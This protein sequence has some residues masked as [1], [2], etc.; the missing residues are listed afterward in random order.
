M[1]CPEKW[2][3]LLQ[4]LLQSLHLQVDS[5]MRHKAGR[6]AAIMQCVHEGDLFCLLHE[7]QQCHQL[8]AAEWRRQHQEARCCLCLPP[9]LSSTRWFLAY[10]TV[11]STATHGRSMQIT[12][13]VSYALE[14]LPG[15]PNKAHCRDHNALHTFWSSRARKCRQLLDRHCHMADQ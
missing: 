7:E 12:Y 14:I 11:R 8:T 4:G 15:L 5:L 2:H 1:F 10:I 9:P 6:Q 3:C 13:P